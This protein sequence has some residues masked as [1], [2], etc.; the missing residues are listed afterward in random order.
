MLFHTVSLNQQEPVSNHLGLC[1][2]RI[3]YSKIMAQSGPSHLY[4][5]CLCSS[6]T[7]E[8]VGLFHVQLPHFFILWI[9]LKSSLFNV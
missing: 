8:N 3:Q 2:Q 5:N 1:E 4:T 7:R 6:C 9:S